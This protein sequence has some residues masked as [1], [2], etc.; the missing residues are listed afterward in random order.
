MPRMYALIRAFKVASRRWKKWSAP[1][2]TSTG[3]PCGRAHSSTASSVNR[4][5]VL[6]VNHESLGAD[7]WHWPFSRRGTDE[8]QRIGGLARA[9]ERLGS[10]CGDEA[11]E[12]EPAQRKTWRRREQFVD[13]FKRGH[14]PQN[15]EEVFGF[16]LAVVMH[17]G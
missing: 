5:V 14:G 2:I 1:G 16:A 3:R 7:F 12:R 6:A 13:A 11:A 15:V 10:V 9:R 4:V 17:A 8:Y